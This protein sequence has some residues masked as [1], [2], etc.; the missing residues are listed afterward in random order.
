MNRTLFSLLC[1][2]LLPSISPLRGQDNTEAQ[3]EEAGRS[4]M[5]DPRLRN[6][7]RSVKPEE[8]TAGAAP[9]TAPE[10]AV[11][12]ATRLFREKADG[13]DT[14]QLKDAAAKMQSDGTIEKLTAKAN[15]LLDKETS[16]KPEAARPP[17]GPSA[18][19]AD[20][21]ATRPAPGISGGAPTP[22]AMP[23]E[24]GAV[25][26]ED[27]SNA[28][29]VPRAAAGGIP[30][31]VA[32]AGG[33][34]VQETRVEPIAGA[35]PTTP[36]IPELPDLDAEDIPAPAPL[37]RKYEKTPDGAYPAGKRQH[38]EILAKESLM[39]NTKGELTFLGNVF[40]DAPDYQMKCDKLL[41][42]LEQGA[43]QDEASEA[44]G[45][46]R[47]I[48]S[49]G[50]VEIKRITVDEKGKK[51]TQIALG[52]LAD[53][54]AINGEFVLSGGP[55]Y[56]QDGDRFVRTSSEDSKIIMRKNGLYEVTG[57]TNRVQISIPIED[58][59]EGGGQ[60]GKKKAKD[61]SPFG[62]G[63]GDALNGLR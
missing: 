38:M 23:L 52:R 51:K 53:Y 42:Y 60:K 20:V 56:I 33:A 2:G 3:I 12:E 34:V 46:K 7:L 57:S 15:E 43:S 17:A 18:P 41:I 54:D 19:V 27:T 30:T 45:M 36:L 5:S 50:M 1:L 22:V 58:K 8:G 13:I 9:R 47:A 59:G 6:V 31:A 37:E 26:P 29:A 4:I 44:S 49:G 40:L 28:P 11:R 39:D 24:N 55:P 10:D 16:A 32:A 14:D 35:T 21:P 62:P 25:A 63:L 48:A 61:D